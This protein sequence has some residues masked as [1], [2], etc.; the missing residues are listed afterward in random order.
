MYADVRVFECTQ[1]S[2]VVD[3]IG[4]IVLLEGTASVNQG[5]CIESYIFDL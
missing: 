1:L 5:G 4:A 3:T 2:A